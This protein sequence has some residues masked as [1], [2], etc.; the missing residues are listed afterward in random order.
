MQN[1]LGEIVDLSEGMWR[2]RRTKH[3]HA[4]LTM[5]VFRLD[6]PAE[7][8]QELSAH[9]GREDPDNP[10]RDRASMFEPFLTHAIKLYLA[11]RMTRWAPLSTRTILS[12]FSHFERWCYDY[13]R[14]QRRQQPLAAADLTFAVIDA[15]RTHCEER[16][17]TKGSYP[18]MITKFYSW[19]RKRH[20][21]GFTREVDR[22]LAGIRFEASLRGHIA[23]MNC[24]R[25]GALEFEER[26]QIDQAIEQDVGRPLDL[27]IVFLLRRTGIRTEAA[28]AIRRRHL[29]IPKHPG[30][31]WWLNIPK[32]KQRGGTRGEV[33]VRR[34][35][36]PRLGEALAALPVGNGSDPP[37]LPIAWRNPNQF[38][39]VALRRWA[40]D[41]DL[42]TGRFPVAQGGWRSKKTPGAHPD[43]AR[44]PLFP[45]RFRRTI[46]T[47]LANQGAEAGTIAAVLDDKTL[48]M[49]T[50]YAQTSSSM[51][52]IL[53]RTLDRHPEWIRVVNLFRG[54]LAEP[55]D[56]G[57]PVI[58]GGVPQLA[59]YDEYFDIGP[60]GFCANPD[61]CTLFP[62]LSCYRCPFFRAAIDQLAHRRSLAQI[63]E[64]LEESV[65]TESDRMAA[66]LERDAAAIIEVLA[67]TVEEMGP[68]GKADARI[69]GTKI[70]AV[71]PG[72]LGTS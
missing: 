38:I 33:T 59:N 24:P 40:N 31:P 10:Q 70:L 72:P 20:Y 30:E 3:S 50:V 66:V 21:G 62:P 55:E 58:L 51:V 9:H 16:L 23:R 12:A 45:Y 37:L 8:G 52:E 64:E 44:L 36:A 41:A 53:A 65:G 61:E 47:M 17:T 28:V 15:Y 57:L 19:C 7:R 13:L 69:T 14:F 56:H 49:A 27:A 34:R 18:F 4:V 67:R 39:R 71:A 48:A 2:M 29:E 43:K 42:V 6:R 32:V 11:Y 5:P 22:E 60:I 1:A 63:K 35:I 25:R 54:R 46:A 26:V 68:I